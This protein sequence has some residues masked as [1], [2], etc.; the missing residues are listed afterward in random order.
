MFNL[1]LENRNVSDIDKYLFEDMYYTYLINL[2]Y[3]LVYIYFGKHLPKLLVILVVTK[4][5]PASIYGRS[6]L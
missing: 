4:K 5:D 6:I 1:I 3:I 2:I